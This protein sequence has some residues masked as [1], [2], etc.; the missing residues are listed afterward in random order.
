MIIARANQYGLYLLS[1]KGIIKN[2][3]TECPLGKEA[4]HEL[5]AQLISGNFS[6]A[7]AINGLGLAIKY[8][9]AFTITR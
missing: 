7:N 1:M 5:K 6:K 4:F 2:K 3:T 8:F 9:N